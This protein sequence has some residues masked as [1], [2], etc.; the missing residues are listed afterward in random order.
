MTTLQAKETSVNFGNLTIKG[1]M[2]EDGSF[3][4]SLL[5]VNE[6][7]SFS[8]SNNAA[9]TLSRDLKRLLG[10][11]FSPSKIKTDTS[12]Q[13]INAL[14]LPEFEKMLVVLDREHQ[15]KKVQQFR[16]A[17]VGLSLT[18]VFSDAFNIKFEK[19]ERQAYLQARPEGKVTRR[20][21][22]DAIKAWCDRNDRPDKVSGYCTYCSDTLNV[23]LF[24]KKSAVLKTERLV[25]SKGL[26]RDYMTS[27]EL[28]A[29]ERIEDRVI[30]LFDAMNIKPTD[31][32]KTVILADKGV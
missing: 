28:R 4:V 11:N 30:L 29:V 24:G 7:I 10:K 25:P 12:R 32:I 18:Q 31:A 6:L 22:T 16:D 27:D 26:L 17:L 13:L 21:M 5:Q 2:F 8:T 15:N 9:N 19:E 3:G 20:T 23:H 1:L 14:T